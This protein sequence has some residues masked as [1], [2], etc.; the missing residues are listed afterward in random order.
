M[1]LKEYLETKRNAD[2]SYKPVGIYPSVC[3]DPRLVDEGDPFPYNCEGGG[4]MIYVG[5]G[6][7]LACLH[8]ECFQKNL[9]ESPDSEDMWIETFNITGDSDY[10]EPYY[11]NH[12]I[13]ESDMW[14]RRIFM[15][16]EERIAE[17]DEEIKRLQEEKLS[18]NKE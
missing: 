8:E 9:K 3:I 12:D 10:G 17:I 14:L 16:K 7:D 2:G 5:E 13:E 15:S 11:S 4:E 6:G 18:I 1:K